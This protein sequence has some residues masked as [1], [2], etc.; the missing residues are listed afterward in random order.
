MANIRPISLNGQTRY[1]VEWGE[2]F[3]L[4]DYL[5]PAILYCEIDLQQPYEV[6]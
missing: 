3:V 6:I 5:S 2:D 1:V 4:F